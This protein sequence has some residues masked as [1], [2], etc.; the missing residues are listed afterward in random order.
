MIIKKIVLCS[1]FSIC[2]CEEV[3]CLSQESL[4]SGSLF[5]KCNML[6]LNVNVG[7]DLGGCFFKFCCVLTN[8]NMSDSKPGSSIN[9][10]DAVKRLPLRKRRCYVKLKSSR[11][12]VNPE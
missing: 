9:G 6:N 2:V 11:K 3:D 4:I 8:G 5:C 12:I 1:L 7:V 10:V